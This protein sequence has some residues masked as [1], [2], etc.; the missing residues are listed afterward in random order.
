[1]Y[2]FVRADDFVYEISQ[3]SG[4]KNILDFS[5]VTVQCTIVVQFGDGEL[6]WHLWSSGQ[7]R[8]MGVVIR[9]E[10]H[11]TSYTLVIQHKLYCTSYTDGGA[12]HWLYRNTVNLFCRPL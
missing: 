5:E 6:V 7:E 2:V 3:C 8:L 12:L 10:G 11:C 4:E 1:M 9:M